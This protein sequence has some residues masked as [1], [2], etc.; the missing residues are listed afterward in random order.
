MKKTK[1][2]YTEEN[3]V[4]TFNSQ[5]K[6]SREAYDNSLAYKN[7]YAKKN[8]RQL[9]L[10]FH[11]EKEAD[12]INWVEAKDNATGYIVSLIRKD[13]INCMVEAKRE[14]RIAQGLKGND[15]K[16][17]LA[18]DRKQIEAEYPVSVPGTPGRKTQSTT[19]RV[20]A[21][22]ERK[23]KKEETANDLSN[24]LSYFGSLSLEE[25]EEILKRSLK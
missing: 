1:K 8:Y 11:R 15:L 4:I 14:E 17:A 9:L 5:K 7:E 23:A 25:Q 3:G 6:L 18:E 16:K 20:K 2:S 13:M 10:R 22:E 12:L 21:M 24:I 19:D